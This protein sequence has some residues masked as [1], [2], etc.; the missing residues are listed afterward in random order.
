MATSLPR[1]ELEKPRDYAARKDLY[2]AVIKSYLDSGKDHRE[3]RLMV[4]GESGQGKSTLINGLIGKEVAVEGSSFKPGT[5]TVDE[6]KFKQ[7]GVNVSIWDTPGFGMGEKADDKTAEQLCKSNCYPFD[8][9]LFCIRMDSTRIP[10]GAHIDTIERLTKMFGKSFWKHCLFVL[11]FANNVEQLCPPNEEIDEFFSLRCIQIEDQ[12]KEALKKRV[13]LGDEDTELTNRVRAV[14]VGSST[15]GK[16]RENPWAL[17]DR[18]DWFI[19]FWI[20]CTEYMQDSAVPALLQVNRH[21]LEVEQGNTTP[22]TSGFSP[23][24]NAYQR[25]I[26]ASEQEI[27]QIEKEMRKNEDNPGT[28]HSTSNNE[29]PRRGTPEPAVAPAASSSVPEQDAERSIHDR[30]IPV[31]EILLRR[32]RDD[33]SGFTKYVKEFATE[34]GKNLKVFGYLAGFFE[35]L[36]YYLGKGWQKKKNE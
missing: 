25:P 19:M 22:S 33:N 27:L 7:N 28:V 6:Y 13:R 2:T 17:P 32:L 34:R 16:Y 1:K 29:P 30:K 23:Q 8:L 12:L 10:N 31:A 21:R 14:P 9:A 26:P 36:Y 4:I 15:K 11:T 35:G 24:V 18:E 5:L 20:E 3:L